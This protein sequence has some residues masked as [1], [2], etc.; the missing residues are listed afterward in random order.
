MVL[1]LIFDSQ[2]VGTIE[3]TLHNVS[4][5]DLSEEFIR[6]AFLKYLGIPYNNNCM[7]EIEEIDDPERAVN[8]SA[9]VLSGDS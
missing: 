3:Y 7:Y 6:S 4:E 2:F 1:K 8:N 5:D 9:S